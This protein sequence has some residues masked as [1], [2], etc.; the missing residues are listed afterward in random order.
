MEHQIDKPSKLAS[1]SITHRLRARLTKQFK[2]V[3]TR[4]TLPRSHITYRI[5]QPDAVDPLLDAAADDPEQNLPY[6]A[7]TW[8]SGIA[9]ADVV[10]TERARFAGQ[11]VLELGCGLGITATA[12]VAAGTR[13]AVTDYAPEALLLC[14]LNALA[15]TG[16]EPYTLQLNWRRP[17]PALFKLAQPPFP[18]VLAAD[19]LYET[20]DVNP[21]LE[22]VE[23]LV[24]P[25]GILWLAEPRRAAAQQ[26]LAVAV[27]HGWRDE[28]EH[29]TGPWSASEDTGAIVNVHRLQRA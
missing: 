17:R 25:G 12:A 20:R 9:L 22:L 2:L 15:N 16:R 18:D 5:C 19:V 10:L 23:R 13:L 29:H 21:L 1:A 26:F 7:V 24:A 8:P 6:W 11:R 27:A 14:R 4:L 3:E 28:V